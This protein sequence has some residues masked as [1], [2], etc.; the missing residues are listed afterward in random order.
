MNTPTNPLIK[1]I[2][3][4]EYI[5]ECGELR[6]ALSDFFVKTK[7]CAITVLFDETGKPLA[8]LLTEVAANTEILYLSSVNDDAKSKQVLIDYLKKS[9]PTHSSV[10][11]RLTDSDANKE[12]ALANKFKC[13][14]TVNLFRSVGSG[15]E[16][17]IKILDD[18]KKFYNFMLKYGYTVKNFNELSDDELSQ[19]K[20]NP[21][22]EFDTGLH[23]KELIEDTVGGFSKTLS[24][25]AIKEG[26][27]VSYN[28]VRHP[29]DKHIIFE[30]INVAVSYR[31]KGVFILPFY[32]SLNEM[33]NADLESGSFAI[34]E[35]NTPAL[36]VV[37]KRFSQLITLRTIQHN[38][39]Y[40]A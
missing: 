21:D 37:T 10:I 25:A 9:V 14:Y 39:I 1:N 17:L 3:L 23:A 2:E 38:Y 28:I 36:N 35:I 13:R 7:N 18:N 6:S 22:N 26:K 11:W 16:R 34:Y 29:D 30:I 32:A 5:T 31:N 15:D 40:N 20:N 12:L 8:L 19:I 24:F 27:V 4:I 33:N